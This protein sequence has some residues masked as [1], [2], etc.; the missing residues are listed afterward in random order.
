MGGNQKF[1]DVDVFSVLGPGMISLHSQGDYMF[2]R[3]GNHC[4]EKGCRFPNVT[5]HPPFQRQGQKSKM[6]RCSARY[7]CL[8]GGNG[9]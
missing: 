3:R 8:A 6:T 1:G 5:W 4:S 9:A 2:L 7:F